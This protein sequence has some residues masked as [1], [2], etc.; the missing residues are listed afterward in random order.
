LMG[1]SDHGHIIEYP[2]IRIAK[3]SEEHGHLDLTQSVEKPKIG[4]RLTIVPNHACAVSNL[5]DEVAVISDGRFVK[6]LRVDA[7]GLVR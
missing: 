7:R 1:F 3:L 4:E 6:M 5:F 2:S